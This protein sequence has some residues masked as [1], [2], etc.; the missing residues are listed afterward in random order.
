MSAIVDRLRRGPTLLLD[1]AFGTMLLSRG[2]P[3]GRPP[4]AWALE[5]PE[6]VSAVHRAYV[7]AGSEA[8]HTSTFGAN[9]IRLALF[10]LAERCEEIHAAAGRLA[11]SA[12]ARFVIA[13]VGPTG[14]YLPPIGDADPEMIHAAFARQGR[15][16][17]RAGVDAIHIETMT[18]L[19]EARIALR[20]LSENAPG[21]PL[22]ASLSFDRKKRGFFTLMGDPLVP[23]LSEMLEMGA[24]A[25]GANCALASRDILDLAREARAAIGDPLIIQPNAG[26]PGVRDGHLVYDQRP[27]EFAAD[28][29][30]LAGEGIA[31]LGGCCGTDPRFIEA[32]GRLLGRRESR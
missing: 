12:Q 9:P 2:L 27:E 15:A 29:A 3:A 21:L 16:I 7:G 1:G 26:Q 13:D 11:Q 10:G 20:A 4:E 23:A 24:A 31:A 19:R 18:D 6:E 22:F 32:L 30:P 8:I 17:A 25:V 5:R 14:V 28:L